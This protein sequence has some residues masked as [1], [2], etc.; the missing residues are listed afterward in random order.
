MLRPQRETDAAVLRLLWGERD[1]RVP[2]HRRL[3]ADGH[4]H[5]AEI[6]ARIRSDLDP[7]GPRLLAVVRRDEGDMIGYCGLVATEHGG[8]D[9]PELAF[10]LLSAAH[11]PGYATEAAHAV[12][13][14]AVLAGYRRLWASVWDWNVASRR[15]LAKLGFRETDRIVGDSAHGRTLLTVREL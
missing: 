3:D 13:E 4:P 1:P 7:G 14:S 5:E 12:I 6:A 11:N 2:P 8:A 10:E 15:V 9:E